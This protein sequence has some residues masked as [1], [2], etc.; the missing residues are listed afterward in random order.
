MI[1]HVYRSYG[2]DHAA[3]VANVITY[4]GRMAVRDAAR[5]LGPAPGAQDAWSRQLGPYSRAM[6]LEDDAAAI[7]ADVRDLA[8]RLHGLPRHLGIHSGG[9]VLCDRPVAEVVPM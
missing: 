5:V 4:R 9:M 2:R 1:Q 7:P 6:D 8:N 3:Q